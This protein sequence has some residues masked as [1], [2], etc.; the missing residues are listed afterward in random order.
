[1]NDTI[2]DFAAKFGKT[3]LK[4]GP[5]PDCGGE[6][7][8]WKHQEK[9]G[10]K[11]TPT[12]PKCGYADLMQREQKKVAEK[13]ETVNREQAIARMKQN[14]II[15]D[16]RAWSYLMDNYNV[17]DDETAR[18]KHQASK[19]IAEIINGKNIHAILTGRP[20]V[21][22]T[23][24][25]F[26]IAQ[27]V[28]EKSNY[29]MNV[30]V[31]SYR[32]LLEQLKFG[33]NDKE[34]YKVIQGSVIND[35]KKVGLVVIDDLGAELGRIEEPSK[36]TTYNLDTLTSLV[37]ARLNKATIFTSNLNSDQIFNLYGE[38]IY[39]RIIN[40]ASTKEGMHAFRFK[41]T[42]DKRKNPI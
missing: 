36:P 14:S 35:L 26:A 41:T 25:G 40:G 30:A 42:E 9:D 22:K 7:Y 15:S 16:S 5:C 10:Q 38:R 3:L 32:E 39:S 37:E 29:K 6:M 27:S 19:W 28:L 20:G 17:Y 11:P 2:Q 21:G 8:Y 33:L 12:C 18:A 24:L 31:V 1:M 4:Y 13:L 23:H 34:A